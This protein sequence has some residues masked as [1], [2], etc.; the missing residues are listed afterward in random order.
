MQR[1]LIVLSA[2]DFDNFTRRATV[3]AICEQ[4]PDTTLLLFSG[5]KGLPVRQPSNKSLKWRHYCTLSTGKGE[6]YLRKAELSI[7]GLLWKPFFRSFDTIFLTDPNQELLLDYIG[8]TQRLTYLIRDPNAL[9]SKNNF[10]REGRILSRN[11]HVFAVSQALCTHYLATY[12]PHHSIDRVTYWPNTVDLKIWDYGKHKQKARDYITNSQMESSTITADTKIAGLVG[13]ITHKTDLDLLQYLSEKH[14]EIQFHI[15]GK[16]QLNNK[17][18][19]KALIVFALHNV[20]YKGYIPL[21]KLPEIVASWDIGLVIEKME[22]DFAG[23]YDANKRYQYVAMGKPFVSYAYNG[24]CK[25]FGDAA[26]LANDK[27]EY[28]KLIRIAVEKSYDE[29]F[30]MYCVQKAK[31]NSSEVRARE[32]LNIIKR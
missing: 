24:E 9:M 16:N 17:D 29:D 3:E 20:S 8:D 4:N 6:K 23:Y 19:Q 28:S 27:E 2:T 21:E 22:G 18:Y 13:N 1:L 25:K 30:Q 11:P 14:T 7:A 26:F 10:Q 32:F 15:Y 5:I 31:E 12:Y